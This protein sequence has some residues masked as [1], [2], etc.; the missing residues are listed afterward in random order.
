MYKGVSRKRIDAL[1]FKKHSMDRKI[2]EWEPM[3]T[4]MYN[5]MQCIKQSKDSE[6]ITTPLIWRLETFFQIDKIRWGQL[7]DDF[8]IFVNVSFL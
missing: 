4:E 5:A 1:I 8:S 2:P 3:L 6:Y 7:P